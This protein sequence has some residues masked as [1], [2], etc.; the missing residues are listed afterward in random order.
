MCIKFKTTTGR[1]PSDFV[2]AVASVH[3][4]YIPITEKQYEFI[5][6]KTRDTGD[7]II[8]RGKRMTFGNADSGFA[9]MPLNN[10]N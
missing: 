6:R 7:I 10:N 5:R 4:P 2:D 1:I 3:R 8:Y 9:L